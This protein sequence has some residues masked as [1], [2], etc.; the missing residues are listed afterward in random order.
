MGDEKNFAAQF[1]FWA[2]KLIFVAQFEVLGVKNTASWP[3]GKTLGVENNISS[4]MSFF[5]F[6]FFI[7]LFFVRLW[8]SKIRFRG[9]NNI[10]YTLGVENKISW[11]ILRDFGRRK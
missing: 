5:I 8:A 9:P 3:T 11:P 4:P 7:F 1:T 10:C 6:Y 2:S